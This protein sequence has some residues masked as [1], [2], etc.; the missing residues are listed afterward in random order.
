MST[1]LGSQQLH[2]ADQDY[3]HTSFHLN[4]R[5][6][7]LRPRATVYPKQCLHYSAL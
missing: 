4:W 6:L 2:V 7:T 1:L 5:A 3:L